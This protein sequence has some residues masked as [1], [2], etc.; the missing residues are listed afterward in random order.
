MNSNNKQSNLIIDADP[1]MGVPCADIDD[2]LAILLAEF[3]RKAD[4]KFIST[5]T[6]NVS[7]PKGVQSLKNTLKFISDP[8]E[9]AQG[10]SAPLMRDF[11]SGAQFGREQLSAQESEL[12]LSMLVDE[13][14]SGVKRNGISKMASQIELSPEPVDLVALGPLTNVALLT[15][16]RKDLIDNINR[17]IIMGGAFDVPGN[18]TP[19]AEFNI[20]ADPEAAKIVF[21]LD[22]EKVIVGLDVTQQASI[23]PELLKRKL[24]DDNKLAKFIVRSAEQWTKY[25]NEIS[26]IDYFHP[27][28]PIAIAYLLDRKLFEED[29]VELYLDVER[30]NT[31]AKEMNKGRTFICR[32]LDQESFLDLFFETLHQGLE[33]IS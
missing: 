13:D 6:G 12:D 21:N 26:G 10:S 31:V 28:D 11:K 16:Q 7:S 18:I 27:H 22:V 3:S 19:Y 17:I 2:N 1:G 30:A 24:P 5:V 8:P 15:L 9:F 23:S 33:Q 25:L 32:E 29:K 20:W 4:L 14:T